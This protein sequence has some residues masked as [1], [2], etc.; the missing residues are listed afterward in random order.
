ML[1]IVVASLNF[2]ADYADFTERISKR[3]TTNLTRFDRV[4]S[5]AVNALFVGLYLTVVGLV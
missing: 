5:S 3:R 2:T 4:L 1:V